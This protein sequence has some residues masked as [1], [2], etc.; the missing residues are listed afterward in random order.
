MAKNG[1]K[2]T[3]FIDCTASAIVEQPLQAVFQGNTIV[4]QL[5]RAPLIAFS[6]AMTAYVEVHGGDEATKN[7]L[8]AAVPFPYTLEEYPLTMMANMR[9]QFQWGQD[10]TLRTW[11]RDSRLDGFSKLIAG[12]DKQ[13]MQKQ[14]IIA[15]LRDQ[16][17]A[18][19][20]NF[21]RLI[22]SGT[23]V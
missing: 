10:K 13:D 7:R 18:A 16:S 22:H 5:L 17:A 12:I 23:V 14:E 3:L 11:I 20:A 8:C 9:N 1:A 21:P 19:M 6:A 15:R 4:P 2:N